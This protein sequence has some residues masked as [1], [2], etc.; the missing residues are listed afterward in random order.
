MVQPGRP[1]VCVGDSLTNF[2][3]PQ[4]LQEMISLPVVDLSCSGITTG[5][6]L[7]ILPSLIKA[8]PQVVVIELGGHDF[9]RGYSRA[10]TERT[11]RRSSIP[12]GR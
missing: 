9:L 6:A 1:V 8:N 3:Y 7:S 10:A 12:A 5:Q 11:C 4:R 2:G